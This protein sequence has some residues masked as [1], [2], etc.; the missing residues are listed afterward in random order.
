MRPSGKTSQQIR[1]T[2]RLLILKVQA[3]KLYS[4]KNSPPFAMRPVCSQETG[5]AHGNKLGKRK[6]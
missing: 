4:K 1:I 5:T 6:G 2:G 3:M